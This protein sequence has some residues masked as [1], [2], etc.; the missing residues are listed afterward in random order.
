[1]QLNAGASQH[2]YLYVCYAATTHAMGISREDVRTAAVVA[3]GVSLL[4]LVSTSLYP[5][6]WG[7]LTK[8]TR[9]NDTI[10]FNERF[11]VQYTAPESFI[12]TNGAD[13]VV[14]TITLKCDEYAATGTKFESDCKAVKI[15]RPIFGAVVIMILALVVAQMIGGVV[16]KEIDFTP[17]KLA[18][19]S[20]IVSFGALFM[21]CY[22][23]HLFR[24]NSDDI[25]TL[26]G[27]GKAY[28]GLI[29]FFSL[30]VF[31][32]RASHVYVMARGGQESSAQ[33][34]KQ[35]YK[36]PAFDNNAKGSALAALLL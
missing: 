18:I 19:Y 23:C 25:G 13:E 34:A 17:W 35:T 4:G 29:I 31:T 7:A 3:T 8:Y 20:V 15:C 28:F 11:N 10:G 30:L 32:A 2:A 6:E 27:A 9:T 33:E 1:M 12:H 22:M 24:R 14:S 5:H 36:N 16:V 21:S 26:N